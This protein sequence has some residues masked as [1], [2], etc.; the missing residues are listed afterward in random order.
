[1]KK[2]FEANVA[3]EIPK[4]KLH[5]PALPW[6]VTED[7]AAV[8]STPP[9][10][11]RAPFLIALVAAIF[12][13]TVYMVTG[14][15]M[16]NEEMRGDIARKESELSSMQMSLMRAVVQKDSVNKNSA[17]LEKKL[18]DLTAQKQLFAGV[19]ESLTKKGEEAETAAAAPA[20]NAAG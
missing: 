12:V 8:G 10:K 2:K 20:P 16:Q 5:E 3:S 4:T 17:Q 13:V 19:I 14:A 9:F 18:T 7:D 1:M 11:V 6:K 15:M